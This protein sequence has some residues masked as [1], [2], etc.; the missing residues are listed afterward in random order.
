MAS[1]V[2][3]LIKAMSQG[4]ERAADELMPQVYD[5]LRH[6]AAKLLRPESSAHTL[7]ATALVNEAFLK[8]C[9]QKRADWK[10]R[11]HFFAV[12][13]QAMRR[14]LIDHARSKSREKRG[15]GIQRVELADDALASGARNIDVLELDEALERLAELDQRL[16]R[17]VELRFFGGMTVPEVAE[18]LEVSVTTIE[19][20]WR[21]IKAWL[22]R[23]LSEQE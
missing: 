12:S 8:L 23:E 15:G 19:N 10:S 14:I 4:D 21:M 2:N 16:A 13:A 3:G 17:I 18:S 1:D 20:D 22:K 7:Q 6:R 9:G 5:E 11:T